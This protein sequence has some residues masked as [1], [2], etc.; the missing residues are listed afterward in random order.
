[1]RSVIGSWAVV[2]LVLCCGGLPALAGGAGPAHAPGDQCAYL[3]AAGRSLEAAEI[4]ASM[5]AA[6]PDDIEAHFLYILAWSSLGERKVVEAQYRQWVDS[7]PDNDA[8]RVGLAI[9]LRWTS[10]GEEI[11]TE[12]GRLLEAPPASPEQ[13][14]WTEY[15]LPRLDTGD[16]GA[17]RVRAL[18]A[19]AEASGSLR[20]Q[21]IA[22]VFR[23]RVEP[24]DNEL[25][26][27]V[28][29]AVRERP[30]LIELLA[31]ALWPDL[32]PGSTSASLRL[33]TET[34]A[35]TALR[36][37]DPVLVHSAEV[38]FRA[39]DD[40]ERVDE[41]SRR[42][43]ELD[44]AWA[45]LALDPMAR[46]I[47]QAMKRYDPE[48]GLAELEAMEERIPPAGELRVRYELALAGMLD[49]LE[50]GADAHWARKR[51]MEAGA[52]DVQQARSFAWSAVRAGEDL[53][54]A[55]GYLDETLLRLEAEDFDSDSLMGAVGYA[56]WL[57]YHTRRIAT[58]H[59]QRARVLAE[60]DRYEEA[61]AALRRACALEERIADH[62]A[63]AD[64]YDELGEVEAAFQHR[65][66]AQALSNE[67][68]PE[69]AARIPIPEKL[70]IAW[71]A[72]P[73]WH[74]GGLDGYMTDRVTALADEDQAP[75]SKKQDELP[76]GADHP[77]MGQTFP[78]LAYQVGK[79]TRHLSNHE[80]VMIVQLWNPG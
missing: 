5:L 6:A 61:A 27:A 49:K 17:A 12:V 73:Y 25:S 62:A 50:Y 34:R 48:A 64:V 67:R 60:L 68:D 75:T 19:A 66:R 32:P 1:V 40:D 22:T 79:R 28:R 53:E 69:A 44:P 45:G 15:Y 31:H 74:P 13:R 65:V 36:G 2:L 47:W 10:R 23:A 26:S 14:F 7:E 4:A 46:A 41:C 54:L 16:D 57:D 80:G 3:V 18:V 39:K 63:L 30:L 56:R 21:Q 51:A 42:L 38:V 33:F 72:R 20:L 59:A 78:D 29:R 58:V 11:E 55:L 8:A 52:I 71:E 70:R 24:V 76:V 37:D 77:L 9:A 43:V 35:E